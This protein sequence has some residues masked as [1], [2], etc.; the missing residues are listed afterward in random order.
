[1]FPTD[2]AE[3]DRVCCELEDLRRAPVITR[4]AWGLGMS[5]VQCP[6]SKGGN[7]FCTEPVNVSSAGFPDPHLLGVA[8]PVSLSGESQTRHYTVCPWCAWERAANG[9]RSE[10]VNATVRVESCKRHSG[11]SQSPPLQVAIRKDFPSE[12]SCNIPINPAR[13]AASGPGFPMEAA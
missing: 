10:R 1:M 9:I 6:M 8:G 13:A 2:L 7:E 12:V 3:L 4:T 5:N 11:G